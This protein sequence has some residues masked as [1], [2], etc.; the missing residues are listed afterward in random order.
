[1]EATDL[2]D[3]GLHWTLADDLYSPGSTRGLYNPLHFVVRLD[4]K[5]HDLLGAGPSGF[6]APGQLNRELILAFSTY[7]HET[8]HWWQH[9]G[10]TTGLMMSLAY[11]AQAHVNRQHLLKVLRDVGLKKSLRSFLSSCYEELPESAR[12]ELNIVLN[13]WHDVEFNRRIIL[14]PMRIDAVLSSPF[15]DSIGHSLEIGLAHTLWVLGA[16]FDRNHMFIPDS[17]RWEA[18]FDRLRQAEVEGFFYGSPI[19]LVPLGALRI[20]EGQARFNQLQYLHLASGG[21]LGWDDLRRIGMMGEVYT[22]AFESFLTL[23]GIEWPDT[24][25]HPIVSLFLLVCDLAI[26]PCDGF[27]R[28]ITDYGSFIQSNDPGFRFMWFSRHVGDNPRLNNAVQRCTRDEF[29]EV[30]TN[31]CRS[32]GCWQPVEMAERVQGWVRSEQSLEALLQ[33]EAAFEFRPENLPIRVCFA[34]Y[35]RFAEDRVRHP[36][37]FCWPAMHFVTRPTTDVDLN[38][39]MTLFNRHR[40]LFVA[41]LYGEIRP[42]LVEGRKESSIHKTFN[43]FYYANVVYDMV[44]QWIVTDGPFTYDYTWLTQRYTT[45]EVKPFADA[46]FESVFG[47]SP[48][49]FQWS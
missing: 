15:F 3:G 5:L 26:N 43:D 34:K 40:P 2:A 32:I 49:T 4:R 37:F 29:V 16:T 9:I 19:K 28:D 22:K 12:K 17:R 18:E 30:S 35:L 8:V 14:D 47:A 48:D 7:F 13:N 44:R 6:V 24:P 21:K 39:A 25:V 27:L 33:E 31:L 23:A 36:E 41:D 42:S 38:T 45:Q 46:H 20:F 11:P 10:S 1:M